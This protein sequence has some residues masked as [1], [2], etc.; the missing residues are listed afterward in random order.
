MTMCIYTVLSLLFAQRTEKMRKRSN[1]KQYTN[2]IETASELYH[3]KRDIIRQIDSNCVIASYML[4]QVRD[5]FYALH[6]D[7]KL[8]QILTERDEYMPIYKAVSSIKNGYHYEVSAAVGHD[9]LTCFSH[10]KFASKTH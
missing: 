8:K 4:I 9:G 5:I 10:K 1:V 7:L 3:H 2:H 6:P